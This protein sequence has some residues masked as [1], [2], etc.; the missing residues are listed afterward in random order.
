MLICIKFILVTIGKLLCYF[1]FH[2]PHIIHTEIIAVY[3]YNPCWFL[4]HMWLI[5]TF[6]QTGRIHEKVVF[7]CNNPSYISPSLLS[8]N[9]VATIFHISKSLS[10]I[11][12][13]STGYLLWSCCLF[14]IFCLLSCYTSI[15]FST[16]KGIQISL[17]SLLF[18]HC[19]MKSLFSYCGWFFILLIQFALFYQWP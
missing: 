6:R 8:E 5:I 16:I 7:K 1:S 19:F 10:L 14:S 2:N 9:A 13:K 17:F 15:S 11:L 3:H 4:I 18:L 12:L